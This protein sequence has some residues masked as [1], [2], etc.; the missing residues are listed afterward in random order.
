MLSVKG[1]LLLKV[2]AIKGKVKLLLDN[3]DQKNGSCYPIIYSKQCVPLLEHS[4][5]QSMC[6]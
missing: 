2:T 6:S 4:S 1:K 5:K 3:P